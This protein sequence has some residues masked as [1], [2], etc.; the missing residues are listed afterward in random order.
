M[1]LDELMQRETLATKGEAIAFLLNMYELKQPHT[2][3]AITK[4]LTRRW[5][6]GINRQQLIELRILYGVLG[7]LLGR[8]K[9]I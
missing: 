8:V 4:S 1:D 7:Q 9:D 5:R 6:E 2:I 3:R